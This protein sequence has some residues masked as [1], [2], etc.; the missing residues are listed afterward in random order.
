MRPMIRYA[1]TLSIALSLAWCAASAHGQEAVIPLV[2]PSASRAAQLHWVQFTMMSGRIVGSSAYV[3]T[4]VRVPWAGPIHRRERLEIDIAP[5]GPPSLQ[6]ELLTPEEHLTVVLAHANEL[7]I[8]RVRSVDNHY[9]VDF[10]Q[11]PGEP[12][13]LELEQAGAKRS[14]T[15]VSFWH[16]Y[17]AE[18]EVVRGHLIPLLELL[19]PAWQLTASGASIEELLI[20]RAQGRLQ[21]DVQRWSRLVA[22]LG[23][24]RFSERQN[25]ERELSKAG[26]AVVP[27]LQSL[28]R[29]QLDAEQAAR[30]RTLIDTLSVG[31]EDRADRIATWLS[32][33]KSVV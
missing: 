12:L 26:Q 1:P 4:N 32:D 9:A 13:M 21:P 14:W 28:D 15:A 25:A 3:G 33:R 10:R 17:I 16:L 29:K 23:S 6:Y 5:S 18:P 8:R 30:V 2:A 20:E 31:Y 24:P 11:L 19:H 22:A 27:Y 7:S